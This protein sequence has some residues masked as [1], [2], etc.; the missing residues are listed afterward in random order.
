MD[1][2]NFRPGDVRGGGNIVSPAKTVSD[3][4]VSDSVV[5][6]VSDTVDGKTVNVFNLGYRGGSYFTV[7]SGHFVVYTDELSSISLTAV[8]KKHSDDS[9]ITSS[10]VSC[11][12]NNGS[13]LTGTTNSSGSVTFSI[14]YDGTV[15]VFNIKLK[16]AGTNSI[17]GCTSY[18]RVIVGTPTGISLV[19]STDIIQTDETSI[20]IATMTGTIGPDEEN[21]PLP[22]QTVNFYEE[23]EPTTLTVSASPNP[24]Q[25][26]DATT[27]TAVLRDLDGSRI[28]GETV[29]IYEVDE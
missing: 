9:A 19:G 24:I 17:G 11:I 8:L 15:N 12:V 21:V 4:D 26:G 5:T 1:V 28:K 23:Y 13:T 20:L 3:F 22:Y 14:P 29:D 10:S 6:S 16:Y 27:I 18:Y 2:I 7:T 25:D